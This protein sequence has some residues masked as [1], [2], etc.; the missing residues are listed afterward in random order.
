MH[1]SDAAA[2]ELTTTPRRRSSTSVA[3]AAEYQMLL[4][5]FIAPLAAASRRQRAC[6]PLA[7]ANGAGSAR[8]PETTS[9]AAQRSMPCCSGARPG[10]SGETKMGS[11]PAA[12]GC[13]GLIRAARG[14]DSGDSCGWD[15]RQ[16]ACGC[17]TLCSQRSL[18][19]HHPAGH[20]SLPSA[21]AAAGQLPILVSTH[22]PMQQ[23]GEHARDAHP[24][25]SNS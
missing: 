24:L 21:N 5:L 25:S 22:E 2:V 4:L 12:V 6:Y 20:T 17:W 3:H 13:S 1:G 18:V 7:R 15:Q 10:G 14:G 23:T 16:R 19:G 11:W 9:V 8:V